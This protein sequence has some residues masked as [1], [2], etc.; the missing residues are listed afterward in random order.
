MAIIGSTG[1]FITDTLITDTLAGGFTGYLVTTA[2]RSTFAGLV[3]SNGKNYIVSGA[4]GT[5]VYAI[6]DL[7][8]I[9]STQGLL[10]GI[11]VARKLLNGTFTISIV[12]YWGPT[13][14]PNT[15]VFSMNL[16]GNTTLVR[17]LQLF[18]LQ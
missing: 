5:P 15:F 13:N 14:V 12:V 6:G 10:T 11:T 4:D 17:M 1:I 8:P 3:G 7:T 2:D 9:L 16:S 18:S